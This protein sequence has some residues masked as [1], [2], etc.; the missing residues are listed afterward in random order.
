[1]NVN[2]FSTQL[3]HMLSKSTIVIF[4]L[5]FLPIM[6]NGQS[7]TGVWKTVDDEDGLDKSHIEI[8]EDGDKYYGKI[9]KLLPAAE[10]DTCIPC[11]GDKKDMPLV[12]MNIIW[13]MK[14]KKDMLQGG[15]ILD[16]KTGKEYK[17]KIELD[18][19]DVLNV[20]GFIGFSLLGRTQ[21]WY[22]VKE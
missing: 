8:Y 9:I 6:M 16:P 3:L 13:E 4:S 5:F 12:G 20:R 15:K 18:S 22:R 19:D 21:Q 14:M 2:Y 11:K 10:G 1:M 7:I 17:C